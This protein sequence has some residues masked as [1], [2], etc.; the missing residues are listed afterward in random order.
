MSPR[1]FNVHPISSTCEVFGMSDVRDGDS[2]VQWWAAV[3]TKRVLVGIGEESDESRECESEVTD[4]G[5]DGESVI[6]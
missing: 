6:S 1:E 5:W 4:W 3:E 2:V